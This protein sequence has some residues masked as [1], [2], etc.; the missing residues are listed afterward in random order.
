[1]GCWAPEMLFDLAE[2][3]IKF[4]IR[5][6]KSETILKSEFSNDSNNYFSS[7]CL[8]FWSFEI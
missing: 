8:E 6:P 5:N 2:S 7:D 1:V 3:L 4:E